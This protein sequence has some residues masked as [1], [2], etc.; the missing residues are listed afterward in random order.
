MK[1]PVTVFVLTLN[2]EKHIQRCLARLTPWAAEV[3]VVDSVST[4]RTQELAAAAGARVIVQPWLGWTGQHQA[5]MDAASYD[6]CFKV[7]ADEL[8]DDELADSAR[9]AILA[10]PDPRTG[11]VIE[12]IEEFCSA[13]MPNMR[14]REKRDSFVRLMNRKHS[15]Y[16]PK[17]LIHE[18]IIVSGPRVHLPGKMLHWRDF[19]LEQRFAQY[20]KQTT[21]EAS[22]MAGHG[23]RWGLRGLVAKPLMRFLWSYVWCGAWRAGTHG[24]VYS[25]LRA[26]GEFMRQA[27]L[28]ELQGV[29]HL[30]DPPPELYRPRGSR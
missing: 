15:Y 22:E 1:A 29:S 30:P 24:L 11:F 10:N 2:E 28:W 20:N 7:D 12:R 21:I 8:L 14:R 17:L 23:R 4:D 16:D 6:W 25:M 13:I 5:A 3:L 19:S 18:E 26:N 27:K 9:T